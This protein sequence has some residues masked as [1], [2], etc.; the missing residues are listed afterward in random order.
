MQTQIQ[1]QIGPPRWGF[2]CARSLTQGSATTADTV[3]TSPWAVIGPRF[4]RCEL[5]ERMNIGD[6]E[7]QVVAMVVQARANGT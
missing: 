7:T 2:E 6:V 1:H 4:R 5:G 3:V